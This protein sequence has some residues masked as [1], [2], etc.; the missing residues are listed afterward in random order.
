M[1]MF[2]KHLTFLIIFTNL[3]FISAVQAEEHVDFNFGKKFLSNWMRNAPFPAKKRPGG[4]FA[5]KWLAGR[6]KM[7]HK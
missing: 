2:E 3:F 6:A 7:T 1:N 4:E 5:Q